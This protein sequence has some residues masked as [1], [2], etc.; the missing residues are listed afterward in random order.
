MISTPFALNLVIIIL[1]LLGW[2]N[3]VRYAVRYSHSRR[4]GHVSITLGELISGS[5]IIV[6]ACLFGIGFRLSVSGWALVA[7]LGL[8]AMV[9]GF[10]GCVLT[11][12]WVVRRSGPPLLDL[13]PY[14]IK[15]LWYMGFGALL[16]YV[17]TLNDFSQNRGYDHLVQLLMGMFWVSV[18][19]HCLMMIQ[20]PLVM[21]ERGIYSF[22]L[23]ARWD[24]ITA[25]DWKERQNKNYL[26][27]LRLHRRWHYAKRATVAIPSI[28]K[29]EVALLIS[30]KIA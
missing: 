23:L 22:Y 25:Y 24:Q 20:C 29:G 15:P 1:S 7:R 19:A 18:L 14:E 12:Y 30:Q 11:W 21:T 9:A 27:K 13:G 8:L 5:L 4:Q 28:Y 2:G 10:W 17:Y 6:V 26:L 16:S 3:L